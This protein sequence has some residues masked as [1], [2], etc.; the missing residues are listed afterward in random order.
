MWL[1]PEI[2]PWSVARAFPH[3]AS[4]QVQQVSP[5][6]GR[7]FHPFAMIPRRVAKRNTLPV[8]AIRWGRDKILY[9]PFWDEWSFEHTLTSAS[10]V[11]KCT[12]WRQSTPTRWLNMPKKRALNILVARS[13]VRRSSEHGHVEATANPEKQLTFNELLSLWLRRLFT[14]T[15]TF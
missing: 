1:E 9:L 8:P 5:R 7:T 3:L 4:P 14:T 15:A 10:D 13:G 11:L 12:L 6:N 2:K